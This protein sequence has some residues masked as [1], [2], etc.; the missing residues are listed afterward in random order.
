MAAT[1]VVEATEPEGIGIIEEADESP[2]KLLQVEAKMGFYPDK[3][4]GLSLGYDFEWF[5][6]DASYV[7]K[8]ENFGQLSNRRTWDEYAANAKLFL[9]NELLYLKAGVAHVDEE[10]EKVKRGWESHASGWS[11]LLG[12]GSR[13]RW[14]SLYLDLEWAQAAFPIQYEQKWKSRL[15]FQN[16]DPLAQDYLDWRNEVAKRAPNSS[17]QLTLGFGVDL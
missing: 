4:I 8:F 12:I 17:R 1:Q 7:K 2:E 9:F 13:W 14:D 3:M 10:V 15:R 11:S 16:K 5:A 6:V